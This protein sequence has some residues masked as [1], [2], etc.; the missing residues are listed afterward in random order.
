MWEWAKLFS[1]FT[2]V[3]SYSRT[4]RL[5]LKKEKEINRVLKSEDNIF[6]YCR[7]RP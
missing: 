4:L 3:E 7:G 1:L 2:S 5:G 6:I